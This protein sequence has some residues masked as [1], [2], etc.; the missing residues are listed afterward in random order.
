MHMAWMRVVCGRLESRYRYSASV[1]YNNFP[2]PPNPTA[3]QTADIESKA[4]AV[5]DA[6]A[7]FPDSTLAD[8]YDPLTMPPT[9]Q[10]AHQALDK[11]TDRAYRPAPFNNE[12]TRVAHLFTLHQQHTAPLLPKKKQTRRKK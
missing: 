5:L 2:W 3:K 11:A 4:Q 8:L 6:R 9:L 10:K 12:A 1:V 7:K